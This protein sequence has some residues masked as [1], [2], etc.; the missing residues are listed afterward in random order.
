MDRVHFWWEKESSFPIKETHKNETN[1]SYW[2][3]FEGGS[4]RN[5]MVY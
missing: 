4:Q 3:Y 2:L 5:K 1:H